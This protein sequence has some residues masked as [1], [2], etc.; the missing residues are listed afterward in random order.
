MHT[1]V[2]RRGKTLSMAAARLSQPDEAG[3]DVERLRVLA[4][5]GD[6]DDLTDDVRT[7]ATPPRL[8][9]PDDCV[10]ADQAPPASLERS[11]I[12]RSL[13]L[14][15][16]PATIGWAVGQPSGEGRISGWLRM[17][18]GRQPDPLLLMLAV[19]SLPPATFDLGVF[20][21]VPTIEL[22]VHIRAR[23]VP[24][25]LRVSHATRNFA[26]GFVEEDAEVW[27]ENDRLVAQS[28]QLARVPT[29]I[30]GSRQRSGDT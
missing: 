25:W 2:L 3:G 18:D 1:E 30:S 13:D 9:G 15:L 14:R 11:P 17:P 21:W 4:T 7:S 29:T 8:P 24:G 16:D 28:R 6:L 5:Y 26:G 12:I 10:R 19:D 22:T 23:P 27:D 20:G